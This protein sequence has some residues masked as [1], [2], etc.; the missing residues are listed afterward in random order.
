M[1]SLEQPTAALCSAEIKALKFKSRLNLLVR[2]SETPMD[3]HL[4]CKNASQRPQDPAVFSHTILPVPVR[5][6]G[7]REKRESGYSR[8]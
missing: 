3:S 6:Q 1:S 4:Q 2:T 8:T 5:E 7:E